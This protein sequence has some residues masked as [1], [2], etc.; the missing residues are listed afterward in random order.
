MRM[1]TDAQ[2][3]AVARMRPD[4]HAFTLLEV[5][6]AVTLFGIAVVVLAASYV[7]VLNSLEA[8]K[9]D[10]ALEQELAF[11]RSQVL[12]QPDLQEIEKGGEVPTPNY[13]TATWTATVTPSETVADL[14][15]VELVVELEGDKAD[16]A[17]RK[18]T[19]SLQVL[20]PDWSEP[21]DRDKLRQKTRERLE[22]AKRFRPL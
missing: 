14:F 22:E 19:Q 20:R 8:V 9:V 6:L 12:L 1:K 18:V 16:V 17:P 11:V 10:Q 7:H 13:G 21:V 3:Q 5:M 2:H 15:R 4:R